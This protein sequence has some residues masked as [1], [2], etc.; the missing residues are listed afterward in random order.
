MVGNVK[1]NDAESVVSMFVICTLACLRVVFFRMFR[2]AIILRDSQ[3]L[4]LLKYFSDR[5]R[6]GSTL[7]LNCCSQQNRER[8]V[9]V[10]G[11]LVY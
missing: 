4:Y 8:I 11:Q 2:V 5:L 6:N 7:R 9:V 3:N 1:C 10:R